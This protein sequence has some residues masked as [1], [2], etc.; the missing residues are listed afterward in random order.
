MTCRQT[1]G[2]ISC[3]PLNWLFIWLACWQ[4]SGVAGMKAPQRSSA[5]VAGGLEVGHLN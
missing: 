5:L 1:P 2:L 3:L 4:G